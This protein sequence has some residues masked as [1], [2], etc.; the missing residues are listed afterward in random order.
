MKTGKSRDPH[1]LIRELFKPE[2]SG[3]DFQ[4]SFL[5][6]ANQIKDE[7]FSPKFMQY[8]NI[9]S[10]YKGKGEKLDLTND[11]GIFLVNIFRSI[12]M[13]MVYQDKYDVVDKNMSDS[14]VGARKKKNIRNHLFVINRVINDVL[15]NKEESVDIGILDYRQCFDSMCL[16]ESMGGWDK[17]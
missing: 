2:V 6:M 10:I 8:A 14:N 17:G 9:V 3:I 12:I 11:R 1:G 7:I 15:V 4:S 5:C 16:E 13:K